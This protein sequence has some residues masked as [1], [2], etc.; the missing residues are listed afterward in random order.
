MLSFFPR[1]VLDR[2]WAKIESVSKGFS[3]YFW[4]YSGHAPRGNAKYKLEYM[5]TPAYVMGELSEKLKSANKF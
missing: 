2:I 3:S 4:K 5:R 1:D